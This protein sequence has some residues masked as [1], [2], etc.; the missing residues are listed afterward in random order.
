M[1]A[2]LVPTIVDTT[3]RHRRWASVPTAWHVTAASSSAHPARAQRH[4]PI[5]NSRHCEDDDRRLSRHLCRQ[6][7]Q[8]RAL[9]H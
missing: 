6:R 4:P 8:P 5:F 7:H 1:H 3:Q 9:D 2:H